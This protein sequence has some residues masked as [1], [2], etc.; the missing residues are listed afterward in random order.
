MP[1]TLDGSVGLE[2]VYC[3]TF[4]PDPSDRIGP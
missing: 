2:V 4:V 1:G 3:K